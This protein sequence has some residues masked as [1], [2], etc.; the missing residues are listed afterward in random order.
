MLA[1]SAGATVARALYG[2][3][4]DHFDKEGVDFA[5]AA[6]LEAARFAAAF[7]GRQAWRCAGPRAPW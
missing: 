2:T 5:T 6:D 3:E 1:A 7:T 4:V